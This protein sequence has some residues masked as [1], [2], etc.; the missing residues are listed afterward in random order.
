[1]KTKSI[2]LIAFLLTMGLFAHAAREFPLSATSIVPS[3]QGKAAVDRDRNGN[4]SLKLDVNHLADP[5]Q[6]NPPRSG[7]VVWIQ[8]P[9]RPPVN[10]GVLRVNDKLEGSFSTTTPYSKFDVFVTAEDNVHTDKPSGPEV[11]RGT[12]VMP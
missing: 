2:L 1:M 4:S 7:Y 8:P 9:D 12:V 11:L 3:A 5:A 10:A 6:L